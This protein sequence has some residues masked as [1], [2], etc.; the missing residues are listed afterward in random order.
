MANALKMEFS[1]QLEPG[2]MNG[3]TKIFKTIIDKILFDL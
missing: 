2:D 1:K 3:H